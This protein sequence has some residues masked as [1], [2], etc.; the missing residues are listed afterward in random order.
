MPDPAVMHGVLRHLGRTERRRL[1]HLLGD[2]EL[3][4]R[5]LAD[6]DEAAFEEVVSRHGPMVRAVCRRVLGPSADADDAFQAAFLVLLRKARSIRRADLLAGWLCAVAYRTARQALRRRSRLG[7]RERAFDELPEPARP[8]DPPRDWLPLFDAALQRLPAKYRDPVVLCEL[9]GVS[10]RDASVR[11]GLT[12]GTLSSRLGRARDLLRRKLGR[13]GFALAAGSALAPSVVPEALTAS[14]V[15]ASVHVSAASVSAVVLTEGVLAAMFASKLKAGALAGS[16]TLLLGVMVGVQVSGPASGAGGP[17]GKDAPTAKQA[18]TEPAKSAPGKRE[19]SKVEPETAIIPAD[20]EPFQGTWTLNATE[21]N[22]RITDASVDTTWTFAGDFLTTGGEV[23]ADAAEAFALNAKAK[24]PTIDF[25]LTQFDPVGNGAL[26]RTSYQGIYRFD[27]PGRLTICYRPR[28]DGVLRPTRFATAPNSGATLLILERAER[29]EVK[30]P[31]AADRGT[32]LHDPAIP[33]RYTQTRIPPPDPAKD[34]DLGKVVGA[35]ELTDVDG[36]TPDALAAQLDARGHPTGGERTKWRWESLR[37][38]QLLPASGPKD[39]VNQAGSISFVAYVEL[40]GTRNP[41]WFTLHATSES[42]NTLPDGSVGYGRSTLRLCGIYKLDGD[43]LVVCLPEAV[44][45]PLL[46]PTDFQGDGE[47]GLYLLTYQRP[48]KNWKPDVRTTPKPAEPPPGDKG[49]SDPAEGSPRADLPSIPLPGAGDGSPQAKPPSI[50]PPDAAGAPPLVPPM[51]IAPVGVPAPA[52]LGPDIPSAGG[53]GGGLIAPPPM[54]P[55]AEDK[56]DPFGKVPDL[57]PPM[58]TT[59]DTATPMSDLDR[60]QGMWV[61]TQV[62]GKPVSGDRS[63]S[64][65]FLKDRVLTQE[66]TYGRIVVDESKSP[67]QITITMQK[68]TDQTVGIYK[69][70]GDRLT[71][72]D[73]HKSSKL[74]PTGFEPDADAGILV[75][76]YERAKPGA[77]PPAGKAGTEKAKRIPAATGKAASDEPPP[78]RDLAKEVEQLREQLQQLEMELKRR[79]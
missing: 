41:K 72:A 51:P 73:C 66:G 42:R 35:W 9:Q 46:R 52:V 50:P 15:A 17:P 75:T 37:R 54:A 64:L 12:E 49:K 8:D 74:V 21:F 77:A 70:E 34:A 3:L 38:L 44:G 4:G 31:P 10:R 14:T 43:K 25:T 71:I 26:V 28:G 39:L 78:P 47:N 56:P 7:T 67:R 36:Q 24:P 61:M 27:S 58:P 6:R 76:V 63:D 68:E 22:G 65:E 32:P 20:C 18:A 13:H 1:Y 33:E 48:T 57:A 62:D 69:I 60:L 11:L 59:R 40:D 2:H 30:A 55:V 53:V 16:A 29:Q 19:P 23:K 45:P 79:K 5:F